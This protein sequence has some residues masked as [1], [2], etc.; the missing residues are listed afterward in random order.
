MSYGGQVAGG[1]S[2]NSQEKLVKK[3]KK[4]SGSILEVNPRKSL[5]FG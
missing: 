1:E 5:I 4:W 3:Q 2:E